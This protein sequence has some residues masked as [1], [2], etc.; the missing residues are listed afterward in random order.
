MPDMSSQSNNGLRRRGMAALAATVVAI[1]A[2]AASAPADAAQSPAAAKG[3]VPVRAFAAAMNA[4][5][6]LG[7]LG[8][9]VPS[10]RGPHAD[11]RRAELTNA[12]GNFLLRRGTFT[13]LPDFPGT[14]QTV[15]ARINNRG[16]TVGV[17][18]VEGAVGAAPTVYLQRK[19][20]FRRVDV[21]GAS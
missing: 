17:A 7:L 6:P 16:Q 14:Q 21:R 4:Q 8:L 10:D 15:H 9:S 3:V 2:G 11:L 13:P 20:E 19:G 18:G 1:V 5:K 12:S